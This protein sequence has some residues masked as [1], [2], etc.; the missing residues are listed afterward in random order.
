MLLAESVN[1][2][3]VYKFG[4][5]QMGPIRDVVAYQGDLRGF[6]FS[7]EPNIRFMT[8]DKGEQANHYFFIN[9]ID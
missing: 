9:T 4:S 2:K 6:L 1:N 3:L 5:Y 7:I 8:T